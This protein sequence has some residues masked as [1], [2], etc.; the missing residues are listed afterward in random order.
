MN[1]KTTT[2]REILKSLSCPSL[3]PSSSLSPPPFAASRFCRLDGCG[4]GATFECLRVILVWFYTRTHVLFTR[5]CSFPPLF[6]RFPRVRTRSRQGERV[7]PHRQPGLQVAHRGPGGPG[8]APRGHGP[9][10]GQTDSSRQRLIGPQYFFFLSLHNQ[11][12]VIFVDLCVLKRWF[13]CTFERCLVALSRGNRQF[14]TSV[15]ERATPSHVCVCVRVVCDAVFF[16]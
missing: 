9:R 3:P 1:N 2:H 11:P 4:H 5:M 13:F 10:A 14:F 7:D 8:G 16:W 6:L 15:A 12:H